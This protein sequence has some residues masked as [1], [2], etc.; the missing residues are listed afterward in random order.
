MAEVTAR[1]KDPLLNCRFRVYIENHPPI[2]FQ[3]IDGLDD[4][5]AVA[6]YR[7]GNEPPRFRKIPGLTTVSNVTMERGVD[8][9]RVLS[10]IRATIS[11][12]NGPNN[13]DG[14]AD[15]GFRYNVIIEVLEKTNIV[16]RRIKM[17]NAWARMYGYGALD[18]TAE[19]E[20][21]KNKLEWVHEGLEELEL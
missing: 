8:P 11:Q 20:I 19:S 4:E 1:K 12:I 15:P 16:A 3:N 14:V 6:T 18:S 10:E 17:H 5:T 21:W 7:E 2:G 9:S 13:G